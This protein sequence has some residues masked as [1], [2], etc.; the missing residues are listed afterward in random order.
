MVKLGRHREARRAIGRAAAQ[1]STDVG[2]SHGLISYGVVDETDAE[3]L[4]QDLDTAPAGAAKEKVA[5]LNAWIVCDSRLADPTLK[6]RAFAA[7]KD[8]LALAVALRW[9]LARLAGAERQI[10]WNKSRAPNDHS[11][12]PDP[13]LEDRIDSVDIKDPMAFAQICQPFL[14]SDWDLSSDILPGWQGL[15]ARAR[16]RIAGAADT[17]LKGTSVD[18]GWIEA[19]LIWSTVTYGYWAL[20]MLSRVAPAVFNELSEKIWEAWMPCVFGEHYQPETSDEVQETILKTAYRRAPARFRE[21]LARFI[22]AQNRTREEVYI[23]DRT[24]PIWDGQI[25]ELLRRKLRDD[26]LSPDPFR[27][28]L[29]ALMNA[30]DTGAM[31][32]AS[33]IVSGA[34]DATPDQIEKPIQAALEFVTQ[35]P[36]AAWKVV[37]RSFRGTTSSQND[38]SPATRSTVWRP[39]FSSTDLASNNWLNGTSAFPICYL[40]RCK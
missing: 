1:L 18:D 25:A 27:R 40:A 5:I 7:A 12:D 10:S 15:S 37:W 19:Q 34:I 3:L 17:Y 28:I 24:T 31:L 23:L 39:P 36:S 20:R 26:S 29:T 16:T 30:G 38:R 6:D 32:I 9:V 2:T 14:D 8:N 21:L 22:D 33:E 11:A 4:F 35:D 13:T